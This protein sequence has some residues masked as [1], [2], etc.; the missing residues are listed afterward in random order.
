MRNVYFISSLVAYLCYFSGDAQQLT[1][2]AEIFE[3]GLISLENTWDEYLSFSSDGKL[4]SFTRQGA[5]L[6]HRNR[7][8][9]LSE[10]VSGKWTKPELAPFSGKAFDRNSSFS[11][12]GNRIYFASNRTEED[13]IGYDYNIWYT[14]KDSKGN[15]S[16]AKK[17]DDIIN[18]TE[19]NEGHPYIAKN[20]NLYFIRYKRGVSTDVYVSKWL[21]GKYQTPQ[22]LGPAINTE[23]PDSH[24]YIDPDERFLI[25][26]A[27][28]R[29][30][31]AGAGD[32]YIS[33]NIDGNW[34]Q[35]VNLGDKINTELYEY[36]AQMGPDNRLYFSRASFD[37]Q[38]PKA[39]DIYSIKVEDI[40]KEK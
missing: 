27:T 35:A 28:G 1:G 31:G 30:D 38:N 13:G 34:T 15:W 2:K 39:S 20:G 12:D 10:K 32:I 26:G 24:C 37:R 19:F 7:R 18:S 22:K 33:Y 3:P 40:T 6:P 21:K 4:A 36:S 25:F 9:Y 17:V 8:I 16:A 11:P 5:E 23:G 29:K 14:E